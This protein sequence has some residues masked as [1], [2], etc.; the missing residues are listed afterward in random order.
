M[1]TQLLGSS[2]NT[3]FPETTERQSEGLQRQIGKLPRIGSH[4]ELRLLSN[5][6]PIEQV[7]NRNNSPK[8]H[9]LVVDDHSVV[10]H[11]ATGWLHAQAGF[12]V[13]GE[14]E[15]AQEAI[16]QAI[17]LKP[18][19]VLLDVGL[20]GE[21]G[22]SAAYKIVRTCPGT[23]VVAFS[24]SADPVHVRGMLAAGATAY[25]L[26]TSE[27]STVLSAIRAVLS[28]SKFL[29]PGLSDTLIEELDIL[30]E[31]SHRSRDV[32]TPREN[33]VLERIVWG[34]TNR[35]MAAEL[36]IKITS[37]NTYRVRLCEKLGLKNRAEV[38]RYGITVGLTKTC[39]P[40][41]RPVSVLEPEGVVSG[42]G[43]TSTGQRSPSVDALRRPSQPRLVAARDEN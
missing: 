38:V 39:P 29:D 23:R 14:A 6:H 31:V 18:E 25:V 19:V 21:G 42:G 11:G 34:Y 37:V 16:A 22:L 35:E 7:G 33:Q 17:V 9:V 20:R 12:E 27:P 26:K 24:A 15:T 13:V 43:K 5:C 40:T 30:P 28:G 32:L 4:S 8:V 1:R 2:G 36:G 41:R 3:K 10:R